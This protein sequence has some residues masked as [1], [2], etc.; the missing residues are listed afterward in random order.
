MGGVQI[1]GGLIYGACPVGTILPFCKTGFGGV[2]AAV[3]NGWLECTGQAIT[4]GKWAGS[5]TPNLKGKF[6]RGETTSG[7]FGGADTHNHG[8]NTGI[9]SSLISISTIGASQAG[10]NRHIHSIS[11]SNNIPANYEVVFILRVV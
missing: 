5:N 1:E 7:T 6:L 9:P 10:D 8:G 2:G 3:P 4:Q 11:T